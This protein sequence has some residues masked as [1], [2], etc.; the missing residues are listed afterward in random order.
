[1]DNH[2]DD[3]YLRRVVMPLE[4]V[5]TRHKRIVVKDSAVNALCY[6][7]KLMLP[8][9]LR[10]ENGI[11]V[12][13]EI[14]VMT[15]KGEAVAVALAQMTTSTLATCDHGCAA[16]V[17]RVIMERDTYPRRWGLGPMASLKKK[18]VAE[19]K[20]DKHGRPTDATPAEYLRALPDVAGGGP[21]A[22]AEAAAAAAGAVKAEEG[23]DDDKKKKKKREGESEEERAARKAAKKAKKEKK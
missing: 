13:D 11:E 9:V 2:K 22:A 5:L 1:M 21:G 17:K 10:Y 19:G 18:L 23:A 12:N 14:V 4:V 16:R 20:L 6:G 15:T 3:A 8:G 7:A